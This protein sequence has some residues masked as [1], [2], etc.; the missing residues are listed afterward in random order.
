MTGQVIAEPYMGGQEIH[1]GGQAST[2]DQPSEPQQ[3]SDDKQE[4]QQ[5]E[6][7]EGKEIDDK[8]PVDK[9]DDW[10]QEPLLSV[11]IQLAIL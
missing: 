9:K 11:Y 6:E 3:P 4:E 8:A 2:D 10:N 1:H 5:E 7:Q